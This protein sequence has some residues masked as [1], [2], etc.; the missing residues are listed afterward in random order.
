MAANGKHWVM[1]VAGSKTWDNYRHQ[2]C[3]LYLLLDLRRIHLFC[4]YV[5]TLGCYRWVA[6]TIPY[7]LSYLK[8]KKKKKN[9]YIYIYILG[10]GIDTNF[11]IRSDSILIHKLAIRF[12]YRFDSISI[13]FGYIS[14]T[15][16]TKFS[17]KK[18]LN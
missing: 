11:M 9:I 7:Q 2:V 14:G 16:H 17:R 12:N 15:V 3:G 18:N 6:S 4:E 5:L 1:L 8:K 10:L 13:I